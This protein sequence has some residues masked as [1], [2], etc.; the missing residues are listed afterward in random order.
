MDAETGSET[1][2]ENGVVNCVEC[3]TEVERERERE[4]E[5][6]KKKKKKKSGVPIINCM[7]DI[8]KEVHKRGFS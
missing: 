8:I 1:I 6:E 5:K 7:V 3:S 4:R 2:E